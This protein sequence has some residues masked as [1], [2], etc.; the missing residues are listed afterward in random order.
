MSPRIIRILTSRLIIEY[1]IKQKLQ[2]VNN[3]SQNVFAFSGTI[4]RGTI[5]SY[6]H[7][8]GRTHMT[9]FAG[10]T[11][12]PLA[13]KVRPKTL[14][15]F[16]GQTHIVGEGQYI[17]KT[18]TAKTPTSMILWGPP[19]VGKTTLARIIAESS[20]WRFIELSAVSAGKADVKKVIEEAKAHQLQGIQTILFIDEIH[21]FN[22]AQQDFLLPFVE[23]GIVTL[24][25]ATT[26]NPSFEVISP[27]LSRTKVI[28][29]ETLNLRDVEEIIERAARKLPRKQRLGVGAK[30]LLA[31]MSGGDARIALNG[32][33]TAAQLSDKTISKKHIEN[34]MQQI[35]LKYDKSGEQHYNTISAFI[36]SMRGSDV[37]ASLFYLQRMLASGED[38]TFIARR[39]VIFAAEDVGMAAPYALTLATSAFMATE[40]VGMP[41]S[42]YIL[43]EATIA[44]ASSKKSRAVAEAMYLSQKSSSTASRRPS[45][46]TFEKRAY[47]VN[48]RSWL[49]GGL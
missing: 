37:D 20:G 16:I 4:F 11:N 18:I 40:R 47:P 30:T 42:N 14:Q 34:A 36:K 22:K 33:E 26:E 1:K 9:L 2:T 35:A 27:L 46:L 29:L 39:L 38:P 43:S 31:Q 23:Q 15:E 12:Q 19:G 21:R 32:L 8:R 44:L 3:I 49:P 7:K 17:E 6:G 24:I 41:E 13:E 48:E 25:G 45:A 10:S 5:G 28:T